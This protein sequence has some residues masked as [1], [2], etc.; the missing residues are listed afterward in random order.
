M[1]D[2]P[3][4]PKVEAM[5]KAIKDRIA[6]LGVDEVVNRLHACG[7]GGG[8]TVEEFVASFNLPEKP[9]VTTVDKTM[10][11]KLCKES[12]GDQEYFA[13]LAERSMKSD[14][15]IQINRLCAL[16]IKGQFY[17]EKEGRLVQLRAI[18][19]NKI[20][21]NGHAY[22]IDSAQVSKGSPFHYDV[23]L[24]SASNS[25]ERLE[26]MLEYAAIRKMVERKTAVLDLSE[27]HNLLQRLNDMH[28]DAFTINGEDFYVAGEQWAQSKPKH[29][30]LILIP[31]G[32]GGADQV[33]KTVP[34]ALIDELIESK[35]TV[36]ILE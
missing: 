32:Q 12:P 10:L 2:A 20:D 1:S 27:D 17:E 16:V 30:D 25:Q 13:S 21:L 35:R 19:E 8:P 29:R 9:K 3:A 15:Y 5:L 26:L 6:D 14:I 7:G 22:V 11:E 34:E 28:E 23:V 33:I 36:F 31:V 4:S 24:V 18:T